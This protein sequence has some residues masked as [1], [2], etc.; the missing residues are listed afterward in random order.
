M[1]PTFATAGGYIPRT[2]PR[3]QQSCRNCNAFRPNTKLNPKSGE[4]RQ[5]W[6]VATP[7]AI[8]QI[9][10]QGING[11]QIGIQGTWP[12]TNADLWCRGFEELEDESD[13]KPAS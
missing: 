3:S 4:P 5:G 13:G 9:P 1:R 7:P 2:L 8:M 10:V 12:T 6:C 11:P